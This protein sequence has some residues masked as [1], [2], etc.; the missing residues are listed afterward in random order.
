MLGV[1]TA[2]DENL[3]AVVTNDGGGY[4]Y[5]FHRFNSSSPPSARP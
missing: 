5:S 1:G 3:A 4:V 2:G